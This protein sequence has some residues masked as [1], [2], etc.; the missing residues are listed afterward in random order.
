VTEIDFIVNIGHEKVAERLK[1][2]I[3][4]EDMKQSITA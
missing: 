3:V 1:Y 4:S 2:V